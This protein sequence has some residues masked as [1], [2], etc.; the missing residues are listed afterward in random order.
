MVRSIKRPRAQKLWDV[1]PHY[2]PV[3]FAVVVGAHFLPLQWIYRTRM[4]GAL[5]VVVAVGPFVL[6]V[7]FGEAALHYTGFFVG[8]TLLVG[9]V[10]A[11]SHATATWLES[12]A[13][14]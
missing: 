11:R 4:Y 9:A 10:L 2:V 14:V 12:Q 3:A 6:A 8:L 7:P 1:S 5:S 13:A